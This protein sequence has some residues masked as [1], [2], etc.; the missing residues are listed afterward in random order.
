MNCVCELEEVMDSLKATL[1]YLS[2]ETEE[3]N[4]NSR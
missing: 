1:L 2:G 4:E 3:N